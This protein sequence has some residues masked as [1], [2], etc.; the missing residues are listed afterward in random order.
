MSDTSGTGVTTRRQGRRPGTNT[1]RQLV[2][3]AARTRFSSDGYSGTTIRKIAGDAGVDPSLVMQFFGS[4]EKLFASVMSIDPSVLETMTQSFDGPLESIG[5][6][7]ARA[8]VKVWDTDRTESEPFLAM[9]RAAISNEHGEAQLREF[10]Q[11]RLI[12]ATGARLGNQPDAALRVGLASSMLIGIVVGRR[13]VKVPALVQEDP[14]TL[15]ALVGP[16]IQALF[17]R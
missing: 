8:F 17:T 9:L 12:H 14:E 5:E 7:V 2:L 15:I 3:D 4:K 11:A 10:I 1:S 13:I 6:R 16:A